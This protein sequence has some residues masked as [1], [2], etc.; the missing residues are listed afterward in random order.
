LAEALRLRGV[1][2][3]FGAVRALDNVSLALPRGATLAVVGESGSGKSTLARLAAGLLA[4]DSGSVVR[5]GRIAMVFQDP[6]GSLD[7]R[8]TAARSIAE[9]LRGAGVATR[10]AELLTAVGLPEGVAARR[11]A[12]LSLGQAQRV[13]IARALAAEPD[14]LICDEPTSALDVSVQAQVLNLL[15]DLQV[16]LG[17]SILLVSHDLGVVRYMADHVAVLLGGRLVETG[18]ADAVLN[19]PRHAYTRQLRAAMA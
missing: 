11:P 16:D 10:V 15:R 17:L 12:Q 13:A 14:L 9:P 4:P 7:P 5:P 1:S 2:R 3:R 6:A 18:P 19:A 8:W